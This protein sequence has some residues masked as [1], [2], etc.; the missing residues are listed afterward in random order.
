[1]AK[2]L[3]SFL[4]TNDYILTNYYYQNEKIEKVRFIQE[5]V[6]RIFCK[7]WN[8][9]D[10]VFIFLTKDAEKNNWTDK[11]YI[12][13]SG[14]KVVKEGLLTRILSMQKDGYLMSFE[15]VKEL[16]EG[17]MENDIWGI[18]SLVFEKISEK[19]EII[20][21]ITHGFRS[22]P[23]LSM[24]LLNYAKFLKNIE[25]KGVYYGAFETLGF[26]NVVKQK[27]IQDRNAPIVDLTSFALLQEWTNG[28]DEFLNFGS[29]DKITKLTKQQIKPILISSEGKDKEAKTLNEFAKNIQEVIDNIKT[30]RGKNIIQG[31]KIK[32]AKNNI[33][34]LK[35]NFIKPLNPILDKLSIKLN[36]FD[37]NENIKNGFVSVKW[38]IDNNLIQQGITLLLETT[39]TAILMQQKLDYKDSKKRMI[40]SSCFS[41]ASQ[42]L[43]EEKWE[44]EVTKNI[45]FTKQILAL[46][47]INDLKGEYEKLGQIR[48]DINHAGFKANSFEANKFE[49]KLKESYE[50]IKNYIIS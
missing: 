20:L 40:V 33:Q 22:I 46:D 2:V 36:D 47:I 29:I 43:V 18:F 1:M 14:E 10:K 27:P 21:D 16:P 50:K 42:G 4:G 3:I 8:K 44:G 37:D 9:E 24:V 13:E 25:I 7:N 5:A 30:C 26:A 49:S 15:A 45:D 11:E 34:E 12:D 38:C 17:L 19:D 32:E 31:V 35:A 28:A 23:M 41:I 48:N 6:M 39:I